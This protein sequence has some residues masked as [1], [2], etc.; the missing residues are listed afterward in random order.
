MISVV[1]IIGEVKII[2][3][4]DIKNAW[5]IRLRN[6]AFHKYSN[7]WMRVYMITFQCFEKSLSA[8]TKSKYFQN[9]PVEINIEVWN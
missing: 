7:S 3:V 8:A 6:S 4:I 9:I 2:I 1:I 5:C